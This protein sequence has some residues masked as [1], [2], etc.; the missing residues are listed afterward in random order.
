VPVFTLPPLA[1]SINSG[2]F[3]RWSAPAATWLATVLVWLL[4]MVL[5]LLSGFFS[6]QFIYLKKQKKAR[7]RGNKK[8]A[9]AAPLLWI[10]AGTEYFQASSSSPEA[11]SR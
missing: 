2:W 8:G 5:C 10:S 7:E 6:K 9:L 11:I 4:C 3:I 1:I